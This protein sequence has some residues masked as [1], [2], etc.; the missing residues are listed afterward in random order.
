LKLEESAEE[1]L[2]SQYYVVVPEEDKFLIT[3]FLLKLK[4]HPFGSKK[5]I[6]FVNSI[7]RCYKL[8]LFLEQFGIKCCTL[9][10]ELPIK[11]RFHIVQEFNR[12]VYDFIIATDESGTGSKPL[13]EVDSEDE[14]ELNESG[15]GSK[16]LTEVDSEDENE[17]NESG[18]GSKPLTEVDS[19]DENE[20]NE[21]GTG[22]KPLTEVDSEDENELNESGTGSKPLTEVDSEDENQ[23]VDL[24]VSNEPVVDVDGVNCAVG[25]QVAPKVSKTQIKKGGQVAPK[26][27]KTQIKKNTFRKVKADGEYGVSRG[28][29]FKNVTAVINFDMPRTAKAYK[30]RVGR[31]A[32]GVGNKG[33]ALSFVCPDSTPIIYHSSKKR[34]KNFQLMNPAKFITDEIILDKIVKRQGK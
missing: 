5:S 12:G 17:L 32:R 21:S 3:Y 4:I 31:T 34:Q 30:H 8:K 2:L 23:P 9:N 7:E 33:Y 19:E 11:S 20:L 26:V 28:I 13:T 25:G 18:T 22:S 6:I 14:N 24:N 10:S 16:P 29:D 27:S 15:T 1:Q